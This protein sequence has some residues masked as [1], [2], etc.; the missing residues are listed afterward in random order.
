[1]GHFARVTKCTNL[2]LDPIAT[3]KKSCFFQSEIFKGHETCSKSEG[4]S[5]VI[6]GRKTWESIPSQFRPLK[7]R[8]NAILT[9]K[10]D[11]EPECGQAQGESETLIYHDFGVALQALSERSDVA[12]IY[13]IGGSEIYNLALSEQ[14]RPYCK[15]VLSTRIN[16]EFESDVF[17]P[18]FEQDFSPLYI[19]QT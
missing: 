5:A 17:M 19:T 15:L 14:F 6:M 9:T 2:S 18:E 11:Y 13:I 7:N 16:K 3:A 1:M 8:I 10:K 4:M 12:E